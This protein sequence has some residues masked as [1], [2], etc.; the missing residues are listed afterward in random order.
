MMPA[1]R[2]KEGRK[3]REKTQASENTQMNRLKSGQREWKR[4]KKRVRPAITSARLRLPQ[5]MSKIVLLFPS[6]SLC[7]STKYMK[8]AR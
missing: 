4:A 6:P 7:A 8:K 2:R 3:E 1:R 5:D